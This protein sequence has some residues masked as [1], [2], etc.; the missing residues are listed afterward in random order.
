MGLFVSAK[1]VIRMA[2]YALEEIMYG[3]KYGIENATFVDVF[4]LTE[5]KVD[6]KTT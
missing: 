1:E 2:K 6:A 5:H 4:R 3:D